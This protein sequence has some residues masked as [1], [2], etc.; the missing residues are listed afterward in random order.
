VHLQDVNMMLTMTALSSHWSDA[1]YLDPLPGCRLS[2]FT[3]REVLT[4]KN[5][6][7][8]K[9]Y[10]MKSFEVQSQPKLNSEGQ[11]YNYH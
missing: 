4:A 7:R 1:G 8:M 2:S 10:D 11:E 3:S 5:I 6:A 9:K